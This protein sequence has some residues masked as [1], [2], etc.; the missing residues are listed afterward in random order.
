MFRRKLVSVP[1]GFLSVVES[2]VSL[3][4]V[5]E[6]EAQSAGRT[7]EGFLPGVDHS[8]LQQPHLTL[9]GLVALAALVRP[10]LRVRPL[11][12]A[13]VAGG[14]EALPAGG[15][16]VRPGAGVDGL[17]LAEALLP[18]EAFPADVAHEGLDLG[19]RH[20][21]VPERAGGGERA[22]AGVALQ[23]CFLQPV[24]RLVD[25]QLAQQ[26]ELP[27]AL[28]AAQQ[29]VG[30]VLLSLPQLVSQ[31]VLLQGLGLVETFVAGAAGERL[32]VTGHVF[33]Q[34]VLLVETFVTEFTKE[35]LLFVQLPPPLPLQLLLLLFTQSCTEQRQTPEHS[36]AGQRRDQTC[37]D[38]QTVPHLVSS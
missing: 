1:E 2:Q 16:G 31:L 14:G 28:V 30:V 6:A 4:V 38:A 27:V 11:V 36:D 19:V 17:V 24:R 12:D 22:V 23:R 18:G 20:L 35:P 37:I 34:L 13:Q 25:S 29:L 7:H 15:A 33:P 3:E 32:D 21:V 26:S 9:E 5:L 10:L 8:M